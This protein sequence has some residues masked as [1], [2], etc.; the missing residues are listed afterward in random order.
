[1]RRNGRDSGG[2]ASL[3][4]RGC[5]FCRRGR[6]HLER[7]ARRDGSSRRRCRCLGEGGGRVRSA[8]HP[9]ATL[10]TT[11]LAVVLIAVPAVAQ[12]SRSGKPAAPKSSGKPPPLKSKTNPQPP[13]NP[14]SPSPAGSGAEPD[15]AYGAYQHG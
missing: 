14:V 2:S 12:A 6:L 5:R 10:T 15:L 8:H 11:V 3:G 13:A 1:M 4:S 7:C 9:M